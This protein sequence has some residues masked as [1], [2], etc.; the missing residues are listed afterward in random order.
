MISATV[1]HGICAQA[2]TATHKRPGQKHPVFF[3]GGKGL[4]VF[5]RTAVKRLKSRLD[6]PDASFAPQ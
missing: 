3:T 6:G 5:V 4:G 2:A 1:G